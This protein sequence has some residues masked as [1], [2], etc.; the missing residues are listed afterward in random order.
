MDGPFAI[1]EREVDGWPMECVVGPGRTHGLEVHS[2]ALSDPRA[3][4]ISGSELRDAL[5]EAYR[6][7][8]DHMR[9]GLKEASMRGA[10]PHCRAAKAGGVVSIKIFHDDQID[11]VIDKVNK[12]IAAHGLRFED[13]GKEHEGWCEYRLWR[14]TAAT[15]ETNE[16]WSWDGEVDSGGEMVEVKLTR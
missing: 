11:R 8:G 2:D 1:E 3:T 5:N 10:G 4:L 6:A 7:G 15:A 16:S 13:D 14:K 9:A 12:A